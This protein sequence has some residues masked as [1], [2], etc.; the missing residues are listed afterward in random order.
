MH[1]GRARQQQISP[2]EQ[3]PLSSAGG[4]GGSTINII[5]PSQETSF[6]EQTGE[7]SPT[8]RIP[9]CSSTYGSQPDQRISAYRE[10]AVE[11]TRHLP[12]SGDEAHRGTRYPRIH[13]FGLIFNHLPLLGTVPSLE[14]PL[15][16]PLPLSL[17][18]DIDWSSGHPA[19][20]FHLIHAAREN[21]L[22]PNQQQVFISL[23]CRQSTRL[24]CPSLLCN[25]S[26]L[27]FLA[28]SPQTI[29]PLQIEALAKLE[30]E[31][32]LVRT[33]IVVENGA[34]EYRV[35]CKMDSMSKR[36]GRCGR[37][38][39]LVK[40]KGV[41]TGTIRETHKYRRWGKCGGCMVAWFCRTECL[42]DA[43]MQ[44]GHWRCCFAVRENLRLC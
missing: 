10:S 30:T 38:E 13:F 35:L 5:P 14:N 4:N 33:G 44:G 2:E 15:V 20:T 19:V 37:W 24:P 8:H 43:W 31:D 11:H 25:P 36:C 18:I 39:A 12:L 17:G 26:D 22:A 32:L 29:T 34:Q 27:H 1:N 28:P 9:V 3:A 40:R 42:Y 21:K 16:S 7:H 23:S 41:N 6:D